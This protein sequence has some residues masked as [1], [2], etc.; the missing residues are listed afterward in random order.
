[1]AKTKGP[2]KKKPL[3]VNFTPS[4]RKRGDQL[5]KQDGRSLSSEM[6]AL[7]NQEWDRRLQAING[8]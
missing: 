1:M 3:N 2:E 7:I 6:E 4:A 8:K 5:A